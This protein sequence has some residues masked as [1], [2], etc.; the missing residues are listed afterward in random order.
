MIDW[1]KQLKTGRFLPGNLLTFTDEVI[2]KKKSIPAS[3]KYLKENFGHMPHRL[4][5]TFKQNEEYGKTFFTDKA[6]NARKNKPRGEGP[7]NNY[8]PHPQKYFTK[9]EG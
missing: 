1:T 6:Q 7:S 3:N 2:K 4:S 8:M 5:G 9:K